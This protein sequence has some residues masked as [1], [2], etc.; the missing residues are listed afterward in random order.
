V[1]GVGGTKKQAFSWTRTQDCSSTRHPH[2]HPVP[3]SVTAITSLIPRSHA[4]GKVPP[5][6]A[7]GAVS[8]WP[9]F[10]FTKAPSPLLLPP[11]SPSFTPA[12][13]PSPPVPVACAR[14]SHQ[15]EWVH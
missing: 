13:T 9:S 1:A 4:T 2:F 6:S 14:Q 8:A 12:H 15:K 5:Q 7:P 11:L 10:A 3:L